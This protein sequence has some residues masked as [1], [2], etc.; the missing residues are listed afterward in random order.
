MGMNTE[1]AARLCRELEE[2]WHAEIPISSAMGV[3]VRGWSNGVLET[4]AELAKN[5]N[6]HGTAF[7]GSLYSI[8]VLTCW[9][10]A[11]LEL[12][13]KTLDAHVVVRSSSIDYR[14][15]VK[16]DIVCRCRVDP[17]SLDEALATLIQNGRCSLDLESR[18][19]VGEKT[20]VRFSASYAIHR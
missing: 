16:G 18:V 17:G 1:E 15:P 13:A 7:A 6:V 11:W 4:R 19:A 8:C 3:T 9:G 14:Y 20:A 10:V 12:R 5:R 2:T